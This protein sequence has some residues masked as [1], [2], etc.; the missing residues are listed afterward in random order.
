MAYDLRRRVR[1]LAVT[2]LAAI[3]AA[4]CATPDES[5][6]PT[7]TSTDNNRDGLPDP[8]GGARDDSPLDGGSSNATGN[9]TPVPGS[10]YG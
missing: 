10:P 6:A 3:V 8:E 2:L 7:D 5:G 1:W 4:G 9:A